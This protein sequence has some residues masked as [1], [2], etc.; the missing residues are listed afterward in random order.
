MNPGASQLALS[1]S[2]FSVQRTPTTRNS[3]RGTWVDNPARQ[4]GL[5]RLDGAARLLYR[6][7]CKGDPSY[8]LP[9]SD[10]DEWIAA[11]I[12]PPYRTPPQIL[13]VKHHGRW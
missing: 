2:L 11:N 5:W 1:T 3:S 10:T 7:S 9:R 13:R 12:S 8:E 6:I 4:P